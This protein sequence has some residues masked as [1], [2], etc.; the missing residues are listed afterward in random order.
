VRR[1]LD[2]GGCAVLLREGEGEDA[3]A[4][5]ARAEKLG[6][7]AWPFLS[8]GGDE[9]LAVLCDQRFMLPA[10]SRKAPRPSAAPLAA[11]ERRLADKGG[12]AREWG[13][14]R[15]WPASLRAN[16]AG[17][18]TVTTDDDDIEVLRDERRR[19]EDGVGSCC[20]CCCCAGG[21]AGGQWCRFMMGKCVR[22]RACLRSRA[23]S[24]QAGCTPAAAAAAGTRADS[25]GR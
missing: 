1:G 19:C 10:P 21:A 12:V 5:R 23:A 22:V 18:L 4:L 24:M 25:G 2:A 8:R 16:E 11:L 13:L 7:P 17:R 14:V 9:V 15:S 20:C 6:C 3:G